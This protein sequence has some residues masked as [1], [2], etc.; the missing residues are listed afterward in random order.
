MYSLRTDHNEISDVMVYWTSPHTPKVI[1]IDP[2]ITDKIYQLARIIQDLTNIPSRENAIRLCKERIFIIEDIGRLLKSIHVFDQAFQNIK[3]E[4]LEVS[5]EKTLIFEDGKE[6]KLSSLEVEFLT[7]F[8]LFFESLLSGHFIESNQTSISLK[9]VK[10]D[11]FDTLFLTLENGKIDNLHQ[12][13][14]IL[15]LSAFFGIR[16]PPAEKFI[17]NM[18]GF[19][20]EEMRNKILKFVKMPQIQGL[21]DS[22]RS[23]LAEFL[24]YGLQRGYYGKTDQ[25]EYLD[26]LR[27]LAPKKICFTLDTTNPVFK[28]VLDQLPNLNELD[29]YR[30]QNSL[31]SGLSHL[32][33]LSRLTTLNLSGVAKLNDENV[34]VV[35]QIKSLTSLDLDFKKISDVAINAFSTLDKLKILKLKYT[36][37]SDDGVKILAQLPSLEFLDLRNCSRVSDIALQHLKL[38]SLQKLYLNSCS[39]SDKGLKHLTCQSRLVELDLQ[40]CERVSDNGLVS[41]SMMTNLTVLSLRICKLITDQGILAISSLKKLSELDISVCENLTDKSLEYLS[42]NNTQ[43]TKLLLLRGTNYTDLGLS[44]LAQLSQ[45]SELD[46]RDCKGISDSGISKLLPLTNLQ[47]LSLSDTRIS[48]SSLRILANFPILTHLSINHCPIYGYA[49]SSIHQMPQLR[50]LIYG[51]KNK[52]DQNDLKELKN[53]FPHL[54]LE[55]RGD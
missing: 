47:S 7:K 21:S 3:R 8:S 46:L 50:T 9:D 48:S 42:I 4:E 28:L 15:E 12:A 34:Q 19:E 1:K 30:V 40:N 33:T 25:Q 16:H 49:L 31:S 37:I 27:N 5:G 13:F 52:F 38:L 23:H 14:D 45:L 20:D 39:I 26:G 2:F 55:N 53:R 22:V 44:H 51:N 35:S 17:E 41:L 18:W 32:R 6:R 36:Q 54:N 29:Q 43:L 10:K 11:A 24:I